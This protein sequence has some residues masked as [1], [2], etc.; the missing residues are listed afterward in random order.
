MLWTEDGELEYLGRLDDQVKIR[1]VRVEPGELEHAIR[2]LDGVRDAA[3]TV[4]GEGGDRG[5]VAYVV[6]P[7]LKPASLRDALAQQ[8]PS[9]LVP[10]A[11]VML[12]SLPVTTNG[13]L[14]RRALPEPGREQPAMVGGT[15]VGP[16]QQALAAVWVD[17]LELR[18]LPGPDD[19][20][21]A[22]GG[23][24]L[25]ALH[26]LTSIEERF[27]RRLSVRTLLAST[28][29]AEQA[30]AIEAT[31]HERA[32][33]TLVPLRATGTQPPF[34]CVLTD[35]RGVMGLRNVLPATLTDQPVFGV[36][37]IDPAVPSWRTSTIEQ[38]AAACLRAVRA[39]RPSGPYRLGGHSIGG[40]VAYEM[41][42]MLMSAGEQVEIL[43]LLDTIAP[44]GFRWPGRIAAR[45]RHLRGSS[46]ERHLRGYADLVRSAAQQTV[47]MARGEVVVRSWPRGF[48]DPWDRA[49]ASRVVRRYHPPRLSAPLMVM[50][51]H[52]SERQLGGC[53]LGWRRYVDR[54]PLTRRL[55]GDHETI[56]SEPDVLALAAALSD[57]F[58]TLSSV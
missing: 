6:G 16:T 49:G 43:I 2:A 38:I 23:D 53:D 54:P 55:P 15:V 27:G 46:L 3:V 31:Q 24:S 48:D 30:G 26:L 8:L 50:S 11:I 40:V 36:Q 20:F 51:T 34:I 19:D 1:G 14:D 39:E 35:H 4:R 10:D 41:A 29:L 56:F 17:V 13:K 44:H 45:H 28:R 52:D 9:P 58:A 42:C 47:A 18:S 25:D 21:F 32:A 7:G 12:E 57:V 37:A 5:L 33:G 22:L